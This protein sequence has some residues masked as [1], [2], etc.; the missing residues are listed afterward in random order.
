MKERVVL[1]IK[2]S[3]FNCGLL[4]KTLERVSSSLSFIY[5]HHRN[6]F[7][8]PVVMDRRLYNEYWLSM[9]QPEAFHCQNQVALAPIPSSA[10]EK[11]LT[12]LHIENTYIPLLSMIS[13]TSTNLAI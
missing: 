2:N 7:V 3:S 10:I 13:G 8:T 6:Q 12:D 4:S 11:L 5:N 9:C 1:I